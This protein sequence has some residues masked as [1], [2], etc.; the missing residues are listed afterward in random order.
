[1]KL[2]IELEIEVDGKISQS[3]LTEVVL[4]D[5]PMCIGSEGHG[6]GEDYMLIVKSAEVKEVK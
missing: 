6:D 5:L 1:M 3:R 4:A 2:I